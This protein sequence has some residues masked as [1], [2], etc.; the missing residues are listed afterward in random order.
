MIQEVEWKKT[1]CGRMDHGGCALLVGIK[2]GRIFRI[3]GDPEGYLNKG[4]VCLKGIHSHKKLYHPK[5]LTK[6]LKRKGKR[7]ENCWQEISWEQALAEVA[8]GLDRVREK[9]G[10]RAVGF[11]QGM[12]KGLEHF[13]LIRLANIFGSPNVVAVQDVCHAPRE[14]TG[15]ATCGF[16]PV[17]DFHHQSRLIILWGSNPPH[18]NEEGEI[19][20]LLLTQLKN[21][22]QLLVVDPRRTELARRAK[23]WLRPRPGSDLFLALS[24]LN[25]IIE[26]GRYDED[27]VKNYCTGF[28]ELAEYVARFSPEATA[29]YTWLD[30]G[31]VRDAARAYAS[32]RPAVI[33]WGNAIEQTRRNYFTAKALISLMAITG[34]LDIAGGNIQPLAPPIMPLGKFVRADLLPNKRKEMIHAY[35][36]AIPRLMTVPPSYFVNAILTGAPYPVKAAYI[37]CANPLVTWAESRRVQQALMQ[38]DFLAVADIFMTPT[39]LLA[40]IVLPAATQFEFNDIGHYG[41]GHGYILARPKIVEPPRGCWPDIK[42]LNQLGRLLTDE[43]L[44]FEDHDELLELL[45]GP[46]GITY[47]QFTE[48]GYLKGD[49]KFEKYKENG[50]KT[51]SQKV[52]VAPM[53]PR[54]EELWEDTSEQF[55]LVL[56]TA[57]SP[58]YLH[59]SYRWLEEL[60]RKEPEPT[61][62]LHPQTAAI[63]GLRNGDYVTIETK[64]GAATQKLIL[65]EAVLPNVVFASYGWWLEIPEGGMDWE[66][67][68]FNMMTSSRNLGKEFGTP[69]LRGIACRIRPSSV[70]G[71]DTKKEF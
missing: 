32:Q 43:E 31:L 20:S 57:K 61:L 23:V 48:I 5:R 70:P 42:I 67:A 25:V 56:T 50:F 14:I 15:F 17:A 34:N 71:S 6:P 63:Y 38:L 8:R 52:E 28:D 24:F 27:F 65:S 36:G 11:C 49:E 59:S 53:G 10:A 4:Y 55:P 9:W 39:A 26:E 35:H 37:Q 33:Q 12:P 1:H 13:V 69:E 47:Q 40:D 19:C 54:P 18:T 21:G 22:A 58:N 64:H 45:L 16:Y 30:P 41:L 46:A 3:K 66:S 60:R 44:W 68:N 62:R 7:G 29:S 51:Q 2:E